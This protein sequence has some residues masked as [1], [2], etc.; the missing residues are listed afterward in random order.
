MSNHIPLERV[1]WGVYCP[2]PGI[3][4]YAEFSFA[5][6]QWK[7]GAP[8]RKSWAQKISGIPGRKTEVI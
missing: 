3:R 4:A 5:E 6:R 7:T 8:G 2:F 1:S